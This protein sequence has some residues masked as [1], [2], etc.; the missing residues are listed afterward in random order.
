MSVT[1]YSKAELRMAFDAVIA[2]WP[3][4]IELSDKTFHV[5][6]GVNIRS[7]NEVHDGVDRSLEESPLSDVAN[8]LEWPIFT[9]I[10]MASKTLVYLNRDQIDFDA[11][12]SIF[13]D[14]PN[15]QVIG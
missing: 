6:G 10:H 9:A 5:N 3:E 15:Y 12:L 13:D 8:A 14:H 1:Q 7:L 11:V 2:R 4:R